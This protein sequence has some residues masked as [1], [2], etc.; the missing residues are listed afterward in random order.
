[1]MSFPKFFTIALI[2][3][4]A[5]S[6]HAKFGMPAVFSDGAILQCDKVIPVWG[7]GEPSTKIAVTFSG[8]TQ[9]TVV[10]ANGR[11][12]VKLDPIAASYEEKT[13]TVKSGADSQEIAKILVGE[14][15]LCMGQSNMESSLSSMARRTRDAGYQSVVQFMAREIRT[16]KD[17]FLRHLKVP[18]RAIFASGEKDFEGS[19][20]SSSPTHN[21]DFSATAYFFAKELRK[22]LDRPVGLLN[23]SWGAQRIDPFIPPSA[24]MASDAFRAGYERTLPRI[25]E[26]KAAYDPISA[27]K[28]Y[29]QALA[30]WEAADKRGRAPFKPSSP[31]EN[32]PGNPGTIFNGMIH[33][34]VPYTIRGALWYQ[35]ES[36]NQNHADKYGAKLDLL[37]SG[38]RKKWGIADLPFYFCQLANYRTPEEEP[39]T[40][41]NNW[42]TISNQLRL[43]SSSIP[44]TGM[45]VLNDIGQEKDIHPRNKYDV[46]LRLSKW[47][48]AKTYG[49]K[50]IVPAG[51]LYHSHQRQKNTIVVT[52]DHSGS[53]L[54]IAK[55]ELM[56]PAQ[57]IEDPLGGFQIQGNDAV[58]K[59]AEAEI[60]APSQIKVS[61]PAISAPTNVRYAWQSNPAKA[62]L[63]NNEGL[64][65]GLFS[66]HSHKPVSTPVLK[67]G[68]S[69]QSSYPRPAPELTAPKALPA[70]IKAKKWN[71][72]RIHRYCAIHKRGPFTEGE[73]TTLSNFDMIQLNS[74]ES[75]LK[76]ATKL[77]N[78]NP[79]I[80]CL[81]Y[82]NVIIWHETFDTDL[83]RDHPD[84]FLKN[85]RNK[86]YETAGTSGLKQKKPLFDLRVPEMRKWWIEDIGRQCDTEELD[87]V[88]ID[89][90]AK[91]LTGWGPKRRSLGPDPK[92]SAAYSKLLTDELL[93]KNFH[94]NKGK[95][96]I[97][98]NAL[99]SG[100]ED[101][102]KSYVDAYFHGSYL[103]WIES[104]SPDNYEEQLSSLIDVCI[105]IGKDP[106]EKVLC[107]QFNAH[108][109]PALKTEA[110]NA[111]NTIADSVIMPEMGQHFDASKMTVAQ[112]AETMK[113][114]FPYKL[115]IFLICANEYS[116]MGYASSHLGNDP[117]FR[118]YPDYPEHQK[119]IGKP[120]GHAIKK[121]AYYYERDFE[122]VSVK[123][124]VQTREAE[125]KWK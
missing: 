5:A 70:S 41:K 113:K 84:W 118:W 92:I 4:L 44:H 83:F 23:T 112:I 67:K 35:G 62:N 53:G 37:V 55:K 51:P 19:W 122:H 74:H 82:R 58:W 14:V 101:G 119:K 117:Q 105:Q 38:I 72:D 9:S 50:K 31:N 95:G 63:Y 100:Y 2:G 94:Q 46:G 47:A 115:A 22:K 40:E 24:W 25:E 11:W 8:K 7:W 80:I 45:A 110:K 12:L 16:A 104:Q 107:F 73:V 18:N 76:L 29:N 77:K 10:D 32:T 34:L 64:P 124:N 54:M 1:M 108:Y 21:G 48:L 109:P 99:R 49:F 81:G 61:H 52:F 6:A 116:Y 36:H 85:F 125:L 86:K 87:G 56:K 66:T 75:E 98:A 26:Q 20:H 90:I 13:M 65:A 33:P 42:V 71:W 15:W 120:L 93:F 123:L 89:A 121:G 57:K 79:N 28:K 59:W 111:T 102:L 30:K 60:I 69:N 3:A 91:V 78:H 68:I 17:P 114:A 106:G 39:V 96:L 97:I 27:E 103:E 43:A 88:L